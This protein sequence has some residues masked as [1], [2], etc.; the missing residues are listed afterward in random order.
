MRTL[1]WPGLILVIKTFAED[2]KQ[3]ALQTNGTFLFAHAFPVWVIRFWYIQIA[4]FEVFLF[5]QEIMLLLSIFVY[6]NADL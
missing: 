3:I 5:L 2:R 4:S 6:T 1:L